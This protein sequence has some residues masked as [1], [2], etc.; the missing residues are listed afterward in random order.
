M[1]SDGNPRSLN[2][3]RVAT[4]RNQNL[5]RQN[6]LKRVSDQ[7]ASKQKNNLLKTTPII[8]TP[9]TSMK[10]VN[11]YKPPVRPVVSSHVASNSP[12]KR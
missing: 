11:E 8:G 5:V 9:T 2:G 7:S 6:L 12:V 4:N 1:N 3:Q 10:K